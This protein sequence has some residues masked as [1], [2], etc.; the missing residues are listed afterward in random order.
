MMVSAMVLL[1]TSSGANGTIIKDA[2]CDIQSAVHGSIH[3]ITT[4][5]TVPS[6]ILPNVP[7]L[8]PPT[9]PLILTLDTNTDTPH[10]L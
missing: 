9:T 6:L 3:C 10:Q 7:L 1:D 4:T 8:L 5:G 2:D